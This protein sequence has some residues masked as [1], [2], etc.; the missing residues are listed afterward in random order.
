MKT[1]VFF[2]LTVAVLSLSAMTLLS[3]NK[4]DED[5]MN[6]GDVT[7]VGTW[8]LI[9]D[10]G[11]KMES[12]YQYIVRPDGKI[13]RTSIIGEYVDGDLR[14]GFPQFYIDDKLKRAEEEP[15]QCTFK[16][17]SIFYE[18]W[19]VAKITIIDSETVKMV[20]TTVG[21]GTLKKIN[22]FIAKPDLVFQYFYN[23]R[24]SFEGKW[25]G[26][27]SDKNSDGSYNVHWLFEM[28]EFGTLYVRQL[29]GVY[30][31]D[32]IRS[33]LS[34]DELDNRLKGDA[35]VFKYCQREDDKLYYDNELLATLEA[36]DYSEFQMKSNRWGNLKLIREPDK[37][38]IFSAQNYNFT[39][40]SPS[41]GNPISIIG[42]WIALRDDGSM[43]MDTQKYLFTFDSEGTFI[44][45]LVWGIYDNHTF[46]TPLSE[47]NFSP[48]KY[49]YC[50]RI[51]ND[52]YY[53]DTK[54]LTVNCT[55][56]DRFTF[57]FTDAY[58][59][60]YSNQSYTVEKV[61]S[62]MWNY[63]WGNSG[64][65]PDEPLNVEEAIAKCKE[66]G[67]TTSENNYYVKGIISSI[68]EV[69][70][71]YGNATFNISDNGEN[72]PERVLTAY[73]IRDLYNK[74]F[75]AEDKIKVGDVVVICGK[76]V[77]YRNNTPEITQGY[78]YSLDSDNSTIDFGMHG[79]GT[80]R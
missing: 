3:C 33:T 47:F 1:K 63:Y 31:H 70:L 60:E 34:Q 54:L 49:E 21:D 14:V 29:E 40:T 61:N 56:D 45:H 11:N 4:D 66:F 57:S 16:G 80:T 6:T 51:G 15:Y 39:F 72:T 12:F 65:N 55:G 42:T 37:L 18:D 64:D 8:A 43:K 73:H 41:S 23:Q 71:S 69:S 27:D 10:E 30:A 79:G 75:E 32:I 20:S 24:V 2:L 46:K 52:L 7:L 26:V 48:Y 77:N 35:T 74:R 62:I 44:V 13:L 17:N 53:N 28:D 25:I 38:Q 76:L 22:R 50:H 59:S 19:E 5:G 68:N 58:I 9:H 67:S 36:T 78:I